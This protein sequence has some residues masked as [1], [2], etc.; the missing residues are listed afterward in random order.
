MNKIAHKDIAKSDKKGPVIK[1]N[2][3]RTVR[4]DGKFMNKKRLKQNFFFKIFIIN[5]TQ[6][7]VTFLLLKK[8]FL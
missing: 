8:L 4:E 3:K 7:L 2:G 6:Q 1:K 5:I